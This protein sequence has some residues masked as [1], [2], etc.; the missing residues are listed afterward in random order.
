MS[1]LK[2]YLVV[3]FT[4]VYRLPTKHKMD[5]ILLQQILLIFDI[6]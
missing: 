2:T 5:S 4:V 1:I 6:H 3:F